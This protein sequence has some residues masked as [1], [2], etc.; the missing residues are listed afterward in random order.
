MFFLPLSQFLLRQ[1]PNGIPLATIYRDLPSSSS[2]IRAGISS[3]GEYD[4][5]AAV[6]K[7]GTFYC[8]TRSTWFA[9]NTQS[10]PHN[11]S[12]LYNCGLRG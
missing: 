2:L 6:S 11:H 3:G 8:E 10:V 1:S 7:P 5:R 4:R 12:K 9:A